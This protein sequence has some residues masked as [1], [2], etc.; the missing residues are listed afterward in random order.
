[1]KGSQNGNGPGMEGALHD[2][3]NALAAARSYGEL[4]LIRA[5]TGV[6]EDPV[7]LL[8]SLLKELERVGDIARSV[9]GGVIEEYQPGDV[10]AC[11]DC[12]Y[13]FVHRKVGKLGSCRRCK[14]Y[15]VARWKPA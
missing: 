14:S 6:K 7:P 11:N 9:R 4:L 1:M 5:Q 3:T 2:L 8:Q 13:T 12:G 10:L 15:Q